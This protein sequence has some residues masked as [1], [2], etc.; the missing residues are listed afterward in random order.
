MTYRERLLFAIAGLMMAGSLFAQSWALTFDADGRAHLPGSVSVAGTLNYFG[1]G[2]SSDVVK[3]SSQSIGGGGVL[4]V[5][6]T[7]LQ[8]YRPLNLRGDTITFQCKVPNPANNPP[9]FSSMSLPCFRMDDA[10]NANALNDLVP[11][12]AIDLSQSAYSYFKGNATHGYRFNNSADTLNLVI[13]ED[14]GSLYIRV[15][16]VGATYQS[17]DKYV[18]VGADGKLRKSAVGPGS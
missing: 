14:D 10:G 7:T 15:L 3:L 11:W 13:I 4:L 1:I 8:D 9:S 17:G 5:T 6:D 2:G 16:A 12:K 18:V